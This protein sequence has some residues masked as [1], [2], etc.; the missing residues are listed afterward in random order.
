MR[1]VK[2]ETLEERRRERI[3]HV[4]ESLA[5]GHGLGKLTDG[6][7]T[8]FTV[9]MP[10]EE[11]PGALLVVRATDNDGKHIAFVGGYRVDDLFLAWEKRSQAGRMKWREDKPWQDR[12]I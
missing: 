2:R 7:L 11:E 3:G 1:D 12:N 9:R 8:G 10:T 4:V 5:H 6:H